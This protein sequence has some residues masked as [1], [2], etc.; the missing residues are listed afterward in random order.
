MSPYWLKEKAGPMELLRRCGG[1]LDIH[2]MLQLARGF[3]IDKNM[4]PHSEVFASFAKS[5]LSY[6]GGQGIMGLKNVT[7]ARMLHQFRMYIDRHNIHYVR[8]CFRKKGMTDEEALEAYVYAPKDMGGLGGR[9]LLREPARLHNK[10]PSDSCYKRYAKGRE[11]KKRL[12]PDFHAEFIVDIE[13]NFVSQW[14]VLEEDSRGRIIGDMEYYR[15]K[16]QRGGEA[17]DWEGAQRQIMDTE[18]FNYANAN[19]AIHRMLDIKPPQKYDTELRRQISARWESPSKR[20]Y[21]YCSDR[22][23]TYSRSNS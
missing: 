2:G 8:K 14:N 21:D 22:G 5:V 18:S 16:Y 9:R 13:G 3:V 10:F 1:Y 19:D 23:D 15:R 20:I 7:E 11:N 12:T 4:P 17:Y 6:C